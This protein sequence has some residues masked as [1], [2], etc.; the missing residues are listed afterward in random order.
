MR[1]EGNRNSTVQ[2]KLVWEVKYLDI[3][4]ARVCCLYVSDVLISAESLATAF[5]SEHQ[6]RTKLIFAACAASRPGAVLAGNWNLQITADRHAEPMVVR[7]D[8][9]ELGAEVNITRA[10]G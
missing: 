8:E 1:V 10:V 9:V 6:D 5:L 3:V 7:I 4:D 2:Q